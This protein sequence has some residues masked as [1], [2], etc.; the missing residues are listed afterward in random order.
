MMGPIIAVPV[1]STVLEALASVEVKVKTWGQSGF[2]LVFSVDKKSPLQPLFLLTGGMPLLFMRCILVATVNGVANVLIDGVITKNEIAPG[3]KGFELHADVVWQRPDR[4]DG[5][6]ELERLSRFRR[7]RARRGWRC[8]W[9]SMRSSACCRDHS[10]PAVRY[11]AAHRT[12]SGA[13]GNGPGV[14]QGAGR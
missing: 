14:H 7:A 1:P 12:D 9:P 8:C 4:A 11:F 3:D 13:A 6:V 5:P 10:Q 2:Q